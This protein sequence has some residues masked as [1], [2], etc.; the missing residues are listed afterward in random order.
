MQYLIQHN[1]WISSLALSGSVE[2]VSSQHAIKRAWERSIRVPNKIVIRTGSLVGLELTE[3]GEVETILVRF[4]N[5]FSRS[6]ATAVL[7]LKEN[8]KA[9]LVTTF[10]GL[11]RD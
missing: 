9:V 7:A 11:A 10:Y 2:L 1:E 6:Y 4:W 5:E 8:N 3:T